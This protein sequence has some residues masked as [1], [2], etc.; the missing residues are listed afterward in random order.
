MV[1]QPKVMIANAAQRFDSN[2]RLSDEPT[3]QIRQIS[4]G[5]WCVM[6]VKKA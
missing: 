5:D 6:W 2:G 3:R 1:S 4:P